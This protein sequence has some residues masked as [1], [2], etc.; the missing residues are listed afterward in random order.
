MPLAKDILNAIKGQLVKGADI[1]LI[2]VYKGCLCYLVFLSL[3]VSLK[4]FNAV[5][6]ECRSL[7][8]GVLAGSVYSQ[9]ARVNKDVARTAQIN[10][11][12]APVRLGSNL[13]VDPALQPLA[14]LVVINGLTAVRDI[15]VSFGLGDVRHF[16]GL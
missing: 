15:I 16:A 9:F 13:R 4:S 2:A 11:L 8:D 10:N 6:V 7:Q 3:K 5:K 1:A 12:Y 14:E